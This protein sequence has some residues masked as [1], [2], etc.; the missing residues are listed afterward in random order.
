MDTR[1]CHLHPDVR[2][3]GRGT[4]TF[5]M[6]EN[7]PPGAG[8][9]RCLRVPRGEIGRHSLRR[10]QLVSASGDGSAHRIPRP[11]VRSSKHSSSQMLTESRARLPT[12][13]N[14]GGVRVRRASTMTCRTRERPRRAP[15]WR[16]VAWVSGCRTALGNAGAIQASSNGCIHSGRRH[17]FRASASLG[18]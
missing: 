17:A 2:D 13:T 7:I 18:E 16:A 6:T 15:L 8:P 14:G 4:G 1:P 9:H 10:D 3:R 12:T 5:E 11:Y